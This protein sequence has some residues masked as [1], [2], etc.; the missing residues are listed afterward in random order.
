MSTFGILVVVDRLAHVEHLGHHL[1]GVAG[2]DPV[3]PG[4]GVEEDRGVVGLGSRFW[5]GDQVLMYSQSSVSGSPYSPIQL[6]PASS[7]W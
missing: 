2:V 6:A 1:A 4:G 3:V 5:Y 7:L